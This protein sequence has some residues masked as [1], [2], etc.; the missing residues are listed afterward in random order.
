MCIRDSM[1]TIRAKEAKVQFAYFAQ[2]N[3]H[4]IMQYTFALF[5]RESDV[6]VATAVVASQ[7]PYPLCALAVAWKATFLLMIPVLYP[8]DAWRENSTSR[9]L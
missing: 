6:F 4:G 2:R 1:K 5:W 7:T 3:E 9:C 8:G